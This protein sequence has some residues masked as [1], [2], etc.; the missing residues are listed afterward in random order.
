MNTHQHQ[1]TSKEQPSGAE[2]MNHKGS[3]AA[4]NANRA[5]R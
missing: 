5:P 2:A 1:H 3:H 4:A